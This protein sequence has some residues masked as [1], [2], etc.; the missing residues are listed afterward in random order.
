MSEESVLNIKI[1]LLKNHPDSISRLAEIWHLLIG[2]IWAPEVPMADI[3]LRFQRHLNDK[4]LPLTVVAFA[5]NLPVGMCSLRENDGINSDLKPWLG[6]LVVDPVY[7]RQGIGKILV[8]AIKQKA[9]N[10]GF[11]R[12]F[13]FAHDT[14]TANY[15]T[16]L[17]WEII[18][19][20]QF[21]GHD[22]IVMEIGL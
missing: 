8:N 4:A 2:K 22:V 21:E 7:Q 20:T 18:K 12:L 14:V 13:L 5:E 9:K 19:N 16:R 11:K 6:S 3:N 10:L 1:D 17:G 15:Y